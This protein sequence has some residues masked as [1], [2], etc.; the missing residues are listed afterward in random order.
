MAATLVA[1]DPLTATAHALHC[2]LAW[3]LPETQFLHAF[4]PAKLDPAVW[5]QLVTRTPFVGIGWNTIDGDKGARTFIGVSRW[6]VFLVVK[7][8]GSGFG[9]R[10][11]GDAQSIGLFAVTCAAVAALQGM[12]IPGV[13]TVMVRSAGNAFA[14][15]WDPDHGAMAAL[16]LEVKTTLSI[17]T[18]FTGADVQPLGLTE[19]SIAWNFDG[20]IVDDLITEPTT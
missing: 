7:N 13:G 8:P 1:P 18:C 4:L 17:A 20:A 3:V 5:K 15:G 12:T 14:E 2:R 10:Y 16:D 9:P 6:T 19:M 11:L